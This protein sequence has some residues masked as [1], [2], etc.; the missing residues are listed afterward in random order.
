MPSRDT[1][2]DMVTGAFSYTGAHIAQRLLASGRDVRTLTFHPERPHQL[3]GQVDALPYRFDEPLALARSLQGVTTLYNT[4]WVRFDHGSASFDGAIA[5][6]RAL[7]HAARRA[8][9]HRI[10]HVSIA[11][12]STDSPLPYYRG[13]ALVEHALAETG[14]PFAV[15][16]PTWIFGGP[17]EILANNIAWILRHIPLF[18]V[19]GDG[20]Y[21]VQP[22]HVDDLADICLNAA[23]ATD[24][25][26]LDAAGPETLTFIEL[27]RAVRHATGSHSPVLHVPAPVISTAARLLGLI[28]GDVL[29][30]PQE[31]RG[32]TSG[33]LVSHCPPLGRIAFTDWLQ[34]NRQSLGRSY[35]NELRRHFAPAGS[36]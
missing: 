10:V 11:N 17:H 25:V 26:I 29:L 19:A 2:V 20:S 16:R 35:A 7:F 18:A 14:V 8:G 24:D 27:V 9:V 12:P 1:N 28:L 33:L 22:V 15:V 13:K 4:Y 23:D 3:R 36:P 30:T 5:N 32:L 21:P 31:I 34:D 6:S